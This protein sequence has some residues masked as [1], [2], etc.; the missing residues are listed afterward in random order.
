MY[1]VNVTYNSGRDDDTVVVATHTSP[2]DALHHARALVAEW[3]A[4][5]GAPPVLGCDV[6]D[7]RD[8]EV[9]A[10]WVLNAGWVD[11]PKGFR[12]SATPTNNRKATP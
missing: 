4:A 12:F 11:P 7:A 3:E 2:V 1:Q 9:T 8:G 5:R 10:M 6:T